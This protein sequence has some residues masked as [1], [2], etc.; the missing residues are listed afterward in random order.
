MIF[1][2]LLTLLPTR[3]LG[4]FLAPRTIWIA[5]WRGCRDRC[6]ACDGA[7]LFGKFLKPLDRC[8]ACGQDWTHHV[9]D[10]FPPYLVILVTGHIVVTGMTLLEAAFHPPSWVHIALWVPLVILLSIG[11]I[12][13]AKGGVIAY[14]WWHGMGGFGARQPLRIAE[15]AAAAALPEHALTAARIAPIAGDLDA[16]S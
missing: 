2:R 6:P 8:P 1:D 3:R 12:Q 16:G 14:Q 11:L 13:P 4:P 7:R 10:D 9:A 15:P 5:L